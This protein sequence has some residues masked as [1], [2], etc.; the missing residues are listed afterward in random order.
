ME[1]LIILGLFYL[2]STLFGRAMKQGEQQRRRGK[3]A[4][5]APTRKPASGRTPTQREA[6]RLEDLLERLGFEVEIEPSPPPA[7]PRP[8]PPPEPEPTVVSL[9][10]PP[11]RALRA[12]ENLDD[13]AAL[14]V[15]RR[16]R[17]AAARSGALTDADHAAF[18]DRI[19]RRPAAPRPARVSRSRL[20][21]AVVWR[22]VLGPPVA[23]GGSGGPWDD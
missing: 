14:V 11:D 4:S 7:A 2:A 9:E 20:Q 18:D 19:R 3:R 1:G 13:Q 21:E 6:E 22:E 23:L 12:Q 8:L 10:L 17:E 15:A 16:I 5:P